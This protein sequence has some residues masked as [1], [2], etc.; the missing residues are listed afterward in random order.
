MAPIKTPDIRSKSSNIAF[1]PTLGGL[2][3]GFTFI[4]LCVIGFCLF[5]RKFRRRRRK[6]RRQEYLKG[7]GTSKVSESPVSSNG[8]TNSVETHGEAG[9]EAEMA[10]DS[11]G[12]VDGPLSNRWEPVE[13]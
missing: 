11:N 12:D 8:N 5:K 9:L 2:I 3:G 4:A 13:V 7:K 10:R 1:G 6:A